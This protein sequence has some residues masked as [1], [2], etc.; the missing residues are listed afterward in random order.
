MIY[1]HSRLHTLEHVLPEQVFSSDDIEDQLSPLYERLGLPKGRLEL[2]TGIK[3]RRLWEP[4]TLASDASAKAGLA[5]LEKSGFDPRELNLLIH[6]SVSRDLMEP[7][8]ASFVHHKM[9]LSQNTQVFDLSNA[10]LGFLNACSLASGLIDAGQIKSALIVA[11][12]NGR[13]LLEGTIQHLLTQDHTRK[14]IKGQFASLTIG[15]GAVAGLITH[16]ML[17]P[18]SPKLIG[19]ICRAD[20]SGSDLCQGGSDGS[21]HLQMQ[22]D[23]EQLLKQ[24][25]ALAK[26]TW[27][28]F[29][30]TLR[31]DVNTPQ[32]Y[33][34]H[35]VGQAHRRLLY[36][37]LGLPIGKDFTS[38]EKFGN[39]GSVSLPM[40]LSMADEA[41][42][43]QSGDSIALLGIGSGI[44]CM[45]MGLQW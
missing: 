32:H 1:K 22:T 20:T 45:M 10:C 28:D 4:G 2:M 8:T 7:A 11:G 12:E 38:F 9:K 40:T 27:S 16:E 43:C 5:C 24:G 26:I 18:D 29:C 42:I 6:C 39:I 31:W 15:C 19:G 34:T 33:I 44:N 17:A 37:S 3:E 21:E 36:E 13:P 25:V 14:S 23:S 30:D 41:G 35:Q